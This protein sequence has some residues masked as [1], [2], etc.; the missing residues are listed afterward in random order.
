MPADT[1]DT[2]DPALVLAQGLCTRLCHDLAGPLGAVGSGV[3]L[4]GDEGGADTQVVGLL[5]DSAEN[6]TARLRFL[7]AVLGAPTARGLEPDGARGLLSDYLTARAGGGA[8]AL[9]WRVGGVDACDAERR[10]RVQVLLNLALVAL[11]VMPRCQWLK[12]TDAGHGPGEIAAGGT[13]SARVALLHALNA[14]ATGGPPDG[15]PSTGHAVYAGMLLR[16][17]G[18]SVH[19]ETMPGALHLVLRTRG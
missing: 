6:A 14:A 18:L 5:S 17:R 16:A 12:V 4:L 3:E 15:D 7:R 13:G 8:P 11:D 9:E 2:M 1:E 10:G 19:A